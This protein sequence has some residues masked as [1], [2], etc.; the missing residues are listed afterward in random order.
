MA[1]LTKGTAVEIGEY[2]NGKTNVI[3]VAD[4]K[5]VALYRKGDGAGYA[6]C[7]TISGTTPTWGSEVSFGNVSATAL[8]R[9]AGCKLADDK[10]AV[11]Y[12]DDD[13]SDAGYVI[14]GS[15]SGT[16]IT[17]GTKV[18]FD[19]GDAEYISCCQ[20]A[21]DKAAVIYNDEGNSD[22]GTICIVTF[23]GTVPSPGTPVV[24][25]SGMTVHT[26]CCLVASDKVI[27]VYRDLND[28]NK[29]KACAFSVS[30]TTPTPGAIV[31]I[32]ADQTSTSGGNQGDTVQIDTD[33]VATLWT[34]C[35][36]SKSYVVILTVSG[37]TITVNTPV[38][39]Y[40]GVLG[41]SGLAKFSTTQFYIV[42]DRAAPDHAGGR[43]ANVSG[44]TITLNDAE[45][46]YNSNP[47][48]SVEAC[49]AIS[50]GATLAITYETDEATD[51]GYLVIGTL[52]SGW[53]HSC[54]GKSSPAEVQGV[55]AASIAAVVGVAT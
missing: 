20:M 10:F 47:T 51:K 3:E 28:T 19:A 9:I 40:A 49:L 25:E 2:S 14:V 29:R 22:Q 16:T 39:C 17:F 53:G 54:L 46:I 23:S 48:F 1:D 36:N 13:V 45:T 52:P 21:T 35:T 11:F 12:G 33:K 24:F 55:E 38:E 34:D 7:A 5:V 8:Q 18:L 32:D 44:A 15:C 50:G 26:N 42:M 6:R 37:T 30:G 41:P 43:L 31:E 4:N 27:A